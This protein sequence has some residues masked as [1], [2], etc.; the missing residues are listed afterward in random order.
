MRRIAFILMLIII[1]VY[2]N[3]STIY[4]NN[5]ELDNGG[6][7]QTNGVNFLW[8]WGTPNYIGPENAHSGQKCWG[9]VIEG[10]YGFTTNREYLLITNINLTAVSYADLEFWHYYKIHDMGG[11]GGRPEITTNNGVD[12]EYLGDYP[13]DYPSSWISEL[14]NGPGYT[15]NYG[16]NWQKAN[17][18][19]TPYCGKMATIRFRFASD[20]WDNNEPGW[21]IDDVVIRDT[22]GNISGSGTVSNSPYKVYNNSTNTMIFTYEAEKNIYGG[23]VTL[24][25]P[26]A[27]SAPQNTDISTAGYIK[28]QSGNGSPI[29]NTNSTIVSSLITVEIT[30]MLQGDDFQIIYGGGS[31][32]A[33]SPNSC[34]AFTFHVQSGRDSDGMQ[35]ISSH[36]WVAVQPMIIPPYTENFESGGGGF[37]SEGNKLEWEYGTPSSVGPSSANSG[38]YC[39]GTGIDRYYDITVW[40]EKMVLPPINLLNIRTNVYLSFYHWFDLYYTDSNMHDGVAVFFSTNNGTEY[41]KV[42]SELGTEYNDFSSMPPFMGGGPAPYNWSQ[43]NGQW[44]KIIVDITS[45]TNKTIYSYFELMCN[46]WQYPIFSGYYLDDLEVQ[47]GTPPV[48]GRGDAYMEPVSTYISSVDY[49]KIHYVSGSVIYNGE[50]SIDVPS[51]WTA[52]QSTVQANP[53]YVCIRSTNSDVS[54]NGTPSISGQR[55]TISITNMPSGK[56]FTVIY[57]NTTA[58]NTTGSVVFTA[59]AGR[60]GETLTEINSSPEVMVMP[61]ISSFSWSNS[62]EVNN[63]GFEPI[64]NPKTFWERGI[65]ATGPSSAHSGSKVW[66]T[67][68]SENINPDYQ[69]YNLYTPFFDLSSI[70]N[71]IVD[72]WY[73]VNLPNQSWNGAQ[74]CISTNQ[75]HDFVVLG[76][77][78]T[79]Y[80]KNNFF[81]EPPD[82]NQQP[83]WADSTD[84]WENKVIDLSLFKGN[85]IQLK[86]RFINQGWTLGYAGF[87]FDD[88][89]I[90]RERP[91]IAGSGDAVSIPSVAEPATTDDFSLKYI[92]ENNFYKGQVTFTVPADWTTPQTGVP[93]GAGYLKVI[94]I[95]SNAVI[96]P[97]P[98]ITGAGPWT[99]TVNITNIPSTGGFVLG[100]SNA[101]PPATPGVSV[102]VVKSALNTETLTEINNSP[103]IVRLTTLTVPFTND[104]DSNDENWVEAGSTHYLW[105]WGT[106]SWGPSSAHSGTRLWGTVL[107]DNYD[108][109]LV[110]DKLTSPIID[111]IAAAQAHLS[112]YHWYKFGENAMGN[113]AGNIMISTNFKDYTV[114]GYCPKNYPNNWG[115]SWSGSSKSGQPGYTGMDWDTQGKWEKRTFNLMEYVG[116]KIILRFEFATPPS[117]WGRL[118]FPGWYIDDISVKPVPP[119]IA[120]T[121][122]ATISP[123]TAIVNTTGNFNINYTAKEDLMDGCIIM[124]FPDSWTAL[125]TNNNL[126][127]GYIQLDTWNSFTYTLQIS[128]SRRL[129]INVQ[130]LDFNESFRIIYK[131]AVAPAVPGEYYFTNKSGD[132]FEGV[133]NI[134][135][136]PSIICQEIVTLPYEEDF[137]DDNGGWITSGNDLF[138]W[139]TPSSVGPSSAKSGTKC[140]GTDLNSFYFV[141]NVWEYLT[142]PPLDVTSETQIY[143]TFYHYYDT[144][145]DPDKNFPWGGGDGGVLEIAYADTLAGLSSAAYNIFGAY[146]QVYNQYLNSESMWGGKSGGWI[147]QSLN[148]SQFKE[149]YIKLRFRFRSDWDYAELPGWYIDDIKIE[150]IIPKEPEVKFVDSGMHIGNNNTYGASF[151]DFDN[152]GDFDLIENNYDQTYNVIWMNNGSGDLS[153]YKS[154]GKN[155]TSVIRFADFNN[156][157][158]FDAIT[159]NCKGISGSFSEQLNEVFINR[160]GK[161]FNLKQTIGN[162]ITR[163]IA[164]CDVDNDGDVD[165]FVANI[166]ANS[167]Y[168]NDGKGNFSESEILLSGGE[169]TAAKFCDL[170]NDGAK[171]IVIGNRNGEANRILLNNGS[172]VLRDAGQSLGKYDTSSVD[173]GDIDADGD[174]DIVFGTTKLI[175]IWTNNGKLAFGHAGDS[176]FQARNIDYTTNNTKDIR[177]VDIDNDGDLDI[178]AANEFDTDMIWLNTGAGIFKDSNNE[179]GSYASKRLSV[180]DFN[181]DGRLDFAVGNSDSQAD[182]IWINSMTNQNLND[183]PSAPKTLSVDFDEN[184]AVITWSSGRDAETPVSFLT[185]NLNVG[186]TPGGNDIFSAPGNKNY[187]HLTD[188]GNVGNGIVSGDSHKWLIKDLTKISY[189]YF[190]IQTVDRGLNGSTWTTVSYYHDPKKPG[191]DDFKVS[192][193]FLNLNANEDGSSIITYNLGKSSTVTIELV[194]LE[195]VVVK[196]ILK[197]ASKPAGYDPYIHKNVWNGKNDFGSKTAPG[198]YWVFVR[199]THWTKKKRV[200]VVW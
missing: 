141:N 121:G 179:L 162:D 113:T 184:T 31:I 1:P 175:Q 193:N 9:T 104:F 128:N 33:V 61:L 118:D 95:L 114:L 160:S 154:I 134:E 70:T 165:I 126:N 96:K 69:I 87:Y 49:Y 150:N 196:T 168:L 137:E 102:F 13:Y 7:I 59:R 133:A 50:V 60:Q 10:N 47:Y 127:A 26:D 80:D 20:G 15:A 177:L 124:V 169:T 116:K 107:D 182:I 119:P 161:E 16:T 171:D 48:A 183:R 14:D 81:S 109:P 178:L 75:G 148:L 144:E 86:F 97:V 36:P 170:N 192:D 21:Y 77:Y 132:G 120:G 103:E 46:N 83:G 200:L 198:I 112:F 44:K 98:D 2:L 147:K 176:R 158:C 73:Y 12:W 92:A 101:T 25:I 129:R 63:G 82:W 185:Y 29:I 11:D 42:E 166:G 22:P 199:T 138:E 74:L 99:I 135:S 174:L 41:F 37:F 3:S 34:T 163:D 145:A 117:D 28:V 45:Y 106:P 27:W 105:D 24:Q 54:V 72:F 38:S 172:G 57:S 19:L 143:L 156:D 173:I 76:K 53:G 153:E 8:E 123:E 6:L 189:Y 122:T 89:V 94:Q 78:P 4:S 90:K 23:K 65:P 146:P 157:G 190:S 39:W 35:S 93:G 108:E 180:A 164:L 142:T 194:N 152:D 43:Q 110:Y 56:E 30:N 188:M 140:W 71:A 195:G 149:R 159:G 52:P 136:S 125:Q 130:G 181:K 5:F 131:K 79:D 40:N 115:F 197:D 151:L 32:G 111:L 155:S 187:Y 67:L 84:D 91:P 88:F 100:Y 58:Q 62:F 191:V 186:T 55:I 66:G 18:D 68:L 51:G 85:K 64:A 17:F 167:L 139:G